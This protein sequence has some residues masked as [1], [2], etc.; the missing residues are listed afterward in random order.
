[1]RNDGGKEILQGYGG[2]GWRRHTRTAGHKTLTRQAYEFIEA[3]WK[4]RKESIERD[5]R[6]TGVF[7]YFFP[8]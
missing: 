6:L 4:W 7:S 3:L 8:S 1:M 2:I 5:A